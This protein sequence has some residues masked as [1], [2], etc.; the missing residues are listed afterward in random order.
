MSY[1][2]ACGKT[3]RV[4][5]R[6]FVLFFVCLFVC[7]V[8]C[9]VLFVFFV[10]FCF[11]S[12]FLSFVFH[13]AFAQSLETVFYCFINADKLVRLAQGPAITFFSAV[14]SRNH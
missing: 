6:C 1:M 5:R 2:W 13:F 12:F 7:L 3:I 10:L 11:V 14:N 9:L 4:P 8:F